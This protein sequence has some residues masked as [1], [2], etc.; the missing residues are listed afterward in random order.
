[1]TSL[2]GRAHERRVI[3]DAVRSFRTPLLAVH[4][5]P[6]IGKT[7]LLQE[8]TTDHRVVTRRGADAFEHEIGRVVEPT[9][10][11][12][13]DLQWAPADRVAELLRR[14]P[15]G[16]V[17]V[18]LAFRTL[19]APA[20][21]ALEAAERNGELIDLP[22][23]PLTPEEAEAVT[24][25]PELYRLSGGNP[26]YLEALANRNTKAIGAAIGQELEA[27]TEPARRLA[28]GMAVA[29]ET[30]DLAAAIAFVLRLA[31]ASR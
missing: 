9:V 20:M 4:G 19:P 3:A 21:T 5:E 27:L 11:V 28:F 10:V 2:A 13:D 26:F 29:G 24:D 15:R 25:D 17:L 7:R 23:G 6:G 14:P 1:M 16:P 30:L 12:L 18:A 8:L 22:L 31:S